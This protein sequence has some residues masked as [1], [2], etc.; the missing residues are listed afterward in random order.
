M[1]GRRPRDYPA[2]YPHYTTILYQFKAEI[3]PLLY[4]REYESL[5]ICVF[6]QIAFNLQ[7]IFDNL[8]KKRYD[9]MQK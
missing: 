5:F 2:N 9:R 4:G 8:N 6:V 3:V 7:I 1:Y